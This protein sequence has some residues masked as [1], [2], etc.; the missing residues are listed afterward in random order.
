M[1][2]AANGPTQTPDFSRAGDTFISMFLGLWAGEIPRPGWFVFSG[3]NGLPLSDANKRSVNMGSGF[4]AIIHRLRA[5]IGQVDQPPFF[6]FPEG[7]RVNE[8]PATAL[9]QELKGCLAC[10]KQF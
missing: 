10:V 4:Q 9:L 7:C 8:L 5:T 2:A 1:I 3:R 6:Q